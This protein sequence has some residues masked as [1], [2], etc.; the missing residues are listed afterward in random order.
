MTIILGVW[1]RLRL[2]L[3]LELEWVNASLARL[4][5]TGYTDRTVK[6]EG[7]KGAAA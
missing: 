7:R 2:R 1:L 3:R 6:A 5:A 4:K